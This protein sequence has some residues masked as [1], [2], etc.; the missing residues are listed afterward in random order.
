MSPNKDKRPEGLFVFPRVAELKARPAPEPTPIGG[1]VRCAGARVTSC[2]EGRLVPAGSPSPSPVHPRR[3][4]WAEPDEETGQMGTILHTTGRFWKRFVLAIVIGMAACAQTGAQTSDQPP[5]AAAFRTLVLGRDSSAVRTVLEQFPDLVDARD[6]RNIPVLAHSNDPTVVQMLLRYGANPRTPMPDGRAVLDYLKAE[7]P[8]AYHRWQDELDL[9][10]VLDK[11]VSSEDSQ[12]QSE[13]HNARELLRRHPRMARLVDPSSGLSV[14]HYAAGLNDIEMA[15][16]AI[17]GGAKA[18]ARDRRGRTASDLCMSRRHCELYRIMTNDFGVAV[19]D[20]GALSCGERGALRRLISHSAN[21]TT[22][23]DLDGRTLLHYAAE[24]GELDDV[25]LLLRSNAVPDARDMRGNTPL[26]LAARYGRTR[27]V[28]ALLD[29]GSDPHARN[30]ENATPLMLACI[31]SETEVVRTLLAVSP[32]AGRDPDEQG[33]YVLIYLNYP[34]PELFNLLLDAGADPSPTDRAR[35][36]LEI[37]AEL[38]YVQIVRRLLDEGV[39]PEPSANGRTPLH[40][41]A[42]AGYAS[43]AS[44]LIR[45]GAPLDARCNVGKTALRYAI[46]RNDSIITFML[47]LRAASPELATG[48]YHDG[49]LRLSLADY[50]AR[51]PDAF[52]VLL[53]YTGGEI[54]QEDR[55][56]RR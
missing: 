18:D 16:L 1:G 5:S 10:A 9:L 47:L 4:R 29:A 49:P 35:P 36:P 40:A 11:A 14:L 46:E 43:V 23:P 31:D 42:D 50:E 48:T 41:A 8:Q 52:A 12:R 32:I 56:N 6:E 24:A 21:A 15:R 30:D 39:L 38:G 19:S 55:V 34:T 26:H 25:R 28:R 7:R 22:T 37:A 53:A 54:P 2:G 45:A 3:D 51:S 44:L 17:A 27:V 13:A 33:K 20:F